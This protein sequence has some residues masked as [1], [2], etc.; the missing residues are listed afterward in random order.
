LTPANLTLGTAYYRLAFA[1]AA[2]TVPSVIPM[3]YVGVNIFPDDEPDTPVH[4]FQD[5]VSFSELGSVASPDY[6][7]K[8]AEAE[9]QVFPY[10][11]AD[12]VTGIMTLDAVVAALSEALRRASWKH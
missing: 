12:L 6:D 5:T 7:P 10:T 1:D 8:R 9:P 4:Y 2:R 3:I 11:E